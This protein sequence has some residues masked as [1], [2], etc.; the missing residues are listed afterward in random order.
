MHL[1]KPQSL[2]ID[3]LPWEKMDAAGIEPAQRSP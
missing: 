2:A 1:P 3:E